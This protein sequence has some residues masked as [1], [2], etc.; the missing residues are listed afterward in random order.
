MLFRGRCGE[1]AYQR[2]LNFEVTGIGH[3]LVIGHRPAGD[4]E[5]GTWIGWLERN[6]GFIPSLFGARKRGIHASSVEAI[7]KILSS[8]PQIRD[9]R[10]HFQHDFD[11]GHEE[12]GA[13]SPQSP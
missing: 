8:S 10:W 1:S 5:Q 12:R 4:T 9:V 11:K 13:S 3:T 6:R 2:Y 7:H